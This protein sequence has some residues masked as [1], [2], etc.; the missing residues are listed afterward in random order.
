MGQISSN[1]QQLTLAGQSQ[2]PSRVN[3]KPITGVVDSQSV[4]D[5]VLDLSDPSR[6]EAEL[7][8]N[9]DQI[10]LVKVGNK[11]LTY[12]PEQTLNLLSQLK[13]NFSTG[14]TTLVDYQAGSGLSIT[15]TELEKSS[16]EQ[17]EQLSQ[18][19]QTILSNSVG[20]LNLDVPDPNGYLSKGHQS[21]ARRLNTQIQA[22]DTQVS[23]INDLIGKLEA[24]NIT[25]PELSDLKAQVQVLTDLKQVM[26]SLK[27]VHE[28]MGQIPDQPDQNTPE[29]TLSELQTLQTELSSHVDQLQASLEQHGEQTGIEDGVD[30]LSNAKRASD[31]LGGA[32]E[33]SRNPVVTSSRQAYGSSVFMPGILVQ[34]E[35]FVKLAENGEA[36]QNGDKMPHITTYR[37]GKPVRQFVSREGQTPD[38]AGFVKWSQDGVR[39]SKSFSKQFSGVSNEIDKFFEQ[40][41][42]SED[43][44]ATKREDF[45]EQVRDMFRTKSGEY[46]IAE[47]Q[48]D[49][50]VKVY[51]D[52]FDLKHC[53]QLSENIET[54]VQNPDHKYA[55]Q[56]LDAF[57]SNRNLSK[58]QIADRRAKIAGQIDDFANNIAIKTVIPEATLERRKNE[59]LA[60]FDQAHAAF[61]ARNSGKTVLDV[62]A[63]ETALGEGLL[64]AQHADN[65][66]DNIG[67]EKVTGFGNQANG[68]ANTQNQENLREVDATQSLIEADRAGIR[69]IGQIQATS[70]EHQ[71]GNIES[72]LANAAPGTKIA[73]F[74]GGGVRVGG[75]VLGLEAEAKAGVRLS[76]TAEK[77]FGQGPAYLLHCDLGLHAEASADF[78]GLFKG[79]VE[80]DIEKTLAGVGFRTEQEVTEYLGLFE[81]CITAFGAGD[82]DKASQLADKILD[83]SASHSYESNSYTVSGGV[84]SEKLHMGAGASYKSTDSEFQ[85]ADGNTEYVHSTVGT[86]KAEYHHIDVEVFAENTESFSDAAHTKPLKVDGVS[87]QS[88]VVVEAKIPGKMLMKA[89][90]ASSLGS[91]P[92]PLLLGMIAQMRTANTALSNVSDEKLMQDLTALFNSVA[93]DPIL[94]AKLDTVASFETSSEF[95]AGVVEM[96]QDFGVTFAMEYSPQHGLGMEIGFDAKF[97]IGGDFGP[98]VGVGVYVEGGFE[99]KYARAF[100]LAGGHHESHEA[101]PKKPHGGGH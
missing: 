62:N 93:A 72:T 12:T 69:Q 66:N 92:E 14:Q 37:E 97:E 16:F 20:R 17:A 47:S 32:I 56:E 76:F 27:A 8:E 71:M 23:K 85:L 18:Q 94:L 38:A 21:S 91:I 1:R 39:D 52:E 101:G 81:E 84:E 45:R 89:V 65:L 68:V 43:Q 60:E 15:Q 53:R 79:K 7:Q 5:G 46:T 61:D 34:Y 49:K 78:W 75:R 63:S 40:P 86:L 3:S 54:Y 10:K 33:L 24:Q 36:K 82:T 95:D 26:T 31:N 42:L 35:Q 64:N 57:F 87:E 29:S 73:M 22:V 41:H 90:R 51:S 55:N 11:Y 2:A 59:M 50:I 96:K 98:P 100:H 80:V 74:V 99:I 25:G 30:L 9:P 77:G 58:G 70:T 88:R 28:K 67:V 13:Q 44:I 83:M 48:V 4:G 6:L 19:S